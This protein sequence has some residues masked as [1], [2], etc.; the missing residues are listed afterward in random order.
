MVPDLRRRLT[1]LCVT[2]SVSALP[3]LVAAPA[4]AQGAQ[5]RSTTA[6]SVAELQQ[7]IDQLKALYEQRIQELEARVATL[8]KQASAT[9]TAAPTTA[10]AAQDE[11]EALRQ[12]A[13]QAA[14]TTPA[15]AVAPVGAGTPTQSDE[16]A[17]LRA[18]AAEAAGGPE[19]P[20]STLPPVSSEPV[21]GHERNLSASN[22]EISFTADVL[23]IT[24][25]PDTTFDPHEFELDFQSALDPYSSAK[26]TLSFGSDSV[27]VEEGYI[28][29]TALAPGL[30]MRFGKM[31][32]TFGALNRWHLH[33]L[34]QPDYPLVLQRF[35]G[36][37][38][39]DQTGVSAEY[40]LPHPW[41]SANEIDLQV[42]DSSNEAFGGGNFQ[43]LVGL[44]H[45]K[46][47]W[48]LSD[49][50][51]LELGLSGVSGRAADNLD[52]RFYGADLT[53]HWQ[54]PARA[55]YRELTWRTEWMRA[56]QELRPRAAA[57]GLG[58]LHLP[59]GP[60]A[61]QLVPRGA[62]RLRRG[63]LRPGAPRVGDRALH[64]LVGERVRAPP[65][66]LPVPLAGGA[67]RGRRQLPAASGLG[68]RPSQARHLL[69]PTDV[70]EPHRRPNRGETMKRT[71]ICTLAAALASAAVASAAPLKVVA[72]L[73]S[74]AAIAK[75]VGGDRVTVQSISQPSEDAHFV[76]PKPS[77]ALMLRDADVFVTT[78][79]DL[80]MWAPVLVDKSGNS[81]IRDGQP[82]YVSASQGVPLLEVPSSTSREA[83]DVHLYGNPHI[84]TSPLNAKII[85]ANIAAGLMRVDPAGAT[86]YQKNLAD[87][88]QRIDVALY[89]QQLADL[90]G[91]RIL[92]PLARDGK[93]IPF[94]VQKQYQ[95]QP[96]I[97]RLGGWMKEGMAFRDKEIVTY[98]KN[99]VYFTTLFGLRVVD[100]IEPKPGI[101]PSA[102]HVHDVID[103]IHKDD[104]KALFT[105]SYFDPRKPQ[106]IAERTGAKAVIVPLEP[107]GM[108]TTDYISLV[109]YWVS[110]LAQAYGGK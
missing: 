81:K 65:C 29:Y 21:S 96:L 48:D 109:D 60:G 86:T 99:W 54:P 107:G 22:P 67:R 75:A 2:L 8:E 72:T 106:E 27:D 49:A 26:L 84:H 16:L 59:G 64:H 58:R 24:S 4:H 37:E 97:G 88:Q 46:N 47:Y 63:A 102:R 9:P 78:G 98:H 76:K 3:L 69:R 31:R 38:G 34:P 36:E 62:L 20:T 77:L 35:F 7:Q 18:A 61:A 91:S 25:S 41:A 93:L 28:R 100:T 66:G 83:G 105:A 1:A 53:L 45:L 15:P 71:L 89:G 104:V 11:L 17:A 108:G 10:P 56:D 85:A 32:E 43:R 23:G 30:T 74:Y 33:A 12:A 57:P 39:L 44:A 19:A 42:T 13:A 50:T 79:L 110:H 80:E 40:L 68:R 52:R 94:L 103:L 87:F 6:Q 5:A 82:G 101:P 95:G 14:G 70:D 73:P 55:K 90:L 92:D 51:Y